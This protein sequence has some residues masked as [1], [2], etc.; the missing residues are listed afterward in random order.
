MLPVVTKVLLH[1]LLGKPGSIGQRELVLNIAEPT[2][3]PCSGYCDKQP[4]QD[5]QEE[6]T[7][8]SADKRGDNSGEMC[9]STC[10]LVEEAL[11]TFHPIQQHI[12]R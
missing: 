4:F 9:L 3:C 7:R 1:D 8:L 6:L 5:V 2:I 12:R 11:H 10:D